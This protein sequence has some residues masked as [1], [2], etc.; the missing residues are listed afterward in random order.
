MNGGTVPTNVWIFSLLPGVEQVWIGDRV[1]ALQLEDTWSK[2][3]DRFIY[4][5]W[6]F[7]CM[8]SYFSLMACDLWGAPVKHC[9]GYS[10]KI[11][12]VILQRGRWI[13]WY[14]NFQVLK[15]S[16]SDKRKIRLNW[17]LER[18]PRKCLIHSGAQSGHWDQFTE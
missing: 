5:I 15:V 14:N 10:E 8:Y 18:S 13:W 16:Y 1:L 6:A 17:I 12:N 3:Q 11:R 9:I 7:H 2:H 4:K